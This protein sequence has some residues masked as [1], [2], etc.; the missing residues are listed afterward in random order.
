MAFCTFDDGAALFDSTPVENM[1]ITE[2]M[3]RA[4]G[5][6]V[7]VYLYGLMLCYHHAERMSL[8]SMAKDL[9]MQEEDV[10]RAMRYWERDG[11]VRRTGDNPVCYTYFN[12][13]Q[14]TLT[15][16]SNPGE[17]LYNR[18]FTDEI[19]RTLEGQTLSSADYSAI[20]DWVDVLELPEEVVIM[21][22]QNEREKSSSGR[23]SMSI[24]GRT[25]RSWAQSGVRTLEDAEKMLIL[26]SARE[27]ELRR[28]LARLGQRRPAS[29]DEKEMYKKWVE[30]WGFS[31]EAVLEACRETTKGTPTM[32]YLDGILLRQHQL[33]RHEVQALAGGMAKEH[34]QR[35]FAREVLAGLGRT[36]VTPTKE[37]LAQ[38]EQWRAKGF[39]EELILQAVRETHAKNAG[40]SL[41]EV[42][43]R[44]QAWRAQGF[45]TAEQVQAAR[46][47]IRALNEQLREIYRAAGLEKRVNQPDR[48]LLARWM[49]E[50]GM[51]ME[52]A[53]LA[54]QYARGSSAPMKAADKIL[55]DWK[56]AGIATPAQAREEHEAH[57]RGAPRTA[58]VTQARPQDAMLRHGYT[59]EQYSA[60]VSD[61]YEEEKNGQP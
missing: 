16:A 38:I 28:L 12:L 55:Y 48:D 61:L 56:Q 31:A 58:P 2:Y 27:K 13:K 59:Q 29:E 17:K 10:E 33:G 19:R 40:G 46:V 37:D 8:S 18:E 60:M 53:L 51:S 11:L 57:L 15:Q 25:A 20:F 36:G 42:E 47:R 52:L 44:L 35:D 24:A 5:D 30:E 50:W 1:F 39:G 45:T 23:V 32:A 49:G 14:M 22:L 43:S 3:L 26:D 54:A 21:L 6:F 34:T 4:P 9:D 7:K 41:E